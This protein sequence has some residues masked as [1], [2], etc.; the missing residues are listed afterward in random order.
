MSELP[1]DST[2]GHGGC[3]D[4]ELVEISG[5]LVF[6]AR[7]GP[8]VSAALAEGFCPSCHG[9]LAGDTGTWCPQCGTSW[10]RTAA[11]WALPLTRPRRGS[12]GPVR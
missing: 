2:A 6:R 5:H 10:Y 8:G 11:A 9:P 3:C 1:H 12:G 4:F 7:P